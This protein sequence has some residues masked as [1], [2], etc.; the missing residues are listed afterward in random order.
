MQSVIET[1]NRSLFFSNIPSLQKV[2]S[3]LKLMFLSLDLPDTKNQIPITKLIF[4][5]TAIRKE[6]RQPGLFSFQIASTDK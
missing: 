2:F 5:L 4:L 3:D 6:K 1:N